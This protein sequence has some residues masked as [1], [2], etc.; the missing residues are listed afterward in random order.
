MSPHEASC[1]AVTIADLVRNAFIEHSDIGAIQIKYH[2]DRTIAVSA[3]STHIGNG[4]SVS[5]PLPFYRLSA[6]IHG[7]AV[8]ENLVHHVMVH[9]HA[10]ASVFYPS[11]NNARIIV[12]FPAAGSEIACL[13]A[14]PVRL[15]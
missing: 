10:S 2:R 14:M 12:V 8:F 13:A 7:D 11:V 1:L 5:E 4:E 9:H 15:P 6:G 3:M